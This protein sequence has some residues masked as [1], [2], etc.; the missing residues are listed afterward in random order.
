MVTV[1]QAKIAED[2]AAVAVRTLAPVPAEAPGWWVPVRT[3]T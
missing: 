3:P 2:A 1:E